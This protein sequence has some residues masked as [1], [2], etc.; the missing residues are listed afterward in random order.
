MAEKMVATLNVAFS[1]DDD[2]LGDK[3]GKNKIT[4]Q[5][6]TKR[7]DYRGRLWA[8]CFPSEG[9]Q[10]TA[11]VGSVEADGVRLQTMYE[12]LKFSNSSSATLKYAGAT[13]VVID[14]TRSVLMKKTKNMYGKTVIVPATDVTLRYDAERSAVIAETSGYDLNDE[15]AYNQREVSIYGACSVRYNALYKILYY[16]PSTQRVGFSGGFSWTLGTLFGYNEYDVATLD[17]ELDT[18]SS[19]DWVEYARVTSKIVLDAKGVWEFPP[20]WESTYQGNKEKIGE[21]RDDYAT[22]GQFSG[23]NDEIDP[24]NSFVD[25]RVHCIVEVDSIGRLRFNDY[26]N[27]GD[28]YWGWFAPYFGSK[29]WNPAYNIQ[30]ADPPGGKKASSSDDFKY[31]LN[32][33]TWRDVFLSVDKSQVIDELQ[34][35]YPGATES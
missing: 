27:G 35:D 9:V 15:L 6:M 14:S 30:F 13:D 1:D 23:F 22:G 19:P 16:T 17:M 24:D 12:G 7:F 20:N 8:R 2:G 29:E 34:N 5:Q 25:T 11:S 28:G 31:D 10:F 32:H 26:N 18:S 33:M 4:L 21:N 3:A